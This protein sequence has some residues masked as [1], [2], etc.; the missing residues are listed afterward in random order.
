MVSLDDNELSWLFRIGSGNGLT[1]ATNTSLPE[2]MLT[3]ITD[4]AWHHQ[5][6]KSWSD[7]N[8]LVQD[9]DIAVLP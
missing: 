9:G 3:E 6:T 4:T 2:P 8:G 7:I 5:A 1:P